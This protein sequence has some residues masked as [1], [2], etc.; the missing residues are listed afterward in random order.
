MAQLQWPREGLAASTTTKN[1]TMKP[2]STHANTMT[3][4]TKKNK[5]E[6]A[7]ANTNVRGKG[8]GQCHGTGKQTRMG[9]TMNQDT[10]GKRRGRS[11][12]TRCE[13]SSLNFLV[14]KLLFLLYDRLLNFFFEVVDPCWVRDLFHP[15]K[16][17]R[18]CPWFAC[19]LES[20]PLVE[21]LNFATALTD[22]TDFSHVLLANGVVQI[23]R[24]LVRYVKCRVQREVILIEVG[25]FLVQIFDQLVHSNVVQPQILKAKAQ[26]S[27][28]SYFTMSTS[29]S[30]A[31]VNRASSNVPDVGPCF[32]CA[33]P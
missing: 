13:N 25:H 5:A 11:A 1:T 32:S 29:D 31:L 33:L 12:L 15:L 16:R 21:T 22:D 24:S 17:P 20:V 30:R 2:R 9:L 14:N 26:W 18:Q 10:T 7:I 27:Y 4:T 6:D 28:W 8:C 3:Q 23:S 19:F